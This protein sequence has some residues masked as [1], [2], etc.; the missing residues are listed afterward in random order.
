MGFSQVADGTLFALARH[1]TH[2]MMVLRRNGS[3]LTVGHAWE[4]APTAELR[5]WPNPTTDHL[6]LQLPDGVN[7]HSVQVLDALG[8]TVPV[9]AGPSGTAGTVLLDVAAL[10]PG[11]YMVRVS[12]AKGAELVR[13]VKH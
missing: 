10:R 6:F 7:G 3:D 5:C 13:W 8:R 11:P 12:S 4:E 1:G 9:R 2:G